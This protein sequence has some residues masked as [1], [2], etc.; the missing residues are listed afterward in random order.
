MGR[1]LARF[2]IIVSSGGASILEEPDL[3]LLSGV[4][5]LWEQSGL[6]A[7]KEKF[8]GGKAVKMIKN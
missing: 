8:L 7:R 6:W 5:G 3:D 2:F 1:V 4:C